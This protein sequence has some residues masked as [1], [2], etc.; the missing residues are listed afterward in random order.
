MLTPSAVNYAKPQALPY[1]LHDE[2]GMYLLVQP[3]GSRWWRMDCRA[4][5][6]R[7]E[8]SEWMDLGSRR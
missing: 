6:R 2:R 4:T 8:E 3:N 5:T 7:Y 1:K